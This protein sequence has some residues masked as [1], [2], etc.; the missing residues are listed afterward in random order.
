MTQGIDCEGNAS[1]AKGMAEEQEEP[2]HATRL[3]AAAN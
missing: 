2:D 1:S 3:L